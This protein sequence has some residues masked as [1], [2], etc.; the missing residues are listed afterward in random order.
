M[1]CCRII[2]PC[3]C[4]ALGL[5]GRGDRRLRRDARTDRRARPAG[6]GFARSAAFRGCSRRSRSIPGPDLA[7]HHVSDEQMSVWLGKREVRDHASR[8]RPHRGDIVAWVPDANVVFSGDL[9]EYHSACYCG[10][11]HFSDWPATLD[12]LAEFEAAGAGA[13]PRRGAGHAREGRGRHRHDAR[14][15]RDALTAR[16]KDSVAEGLTLKQAFDAAHA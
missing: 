16:A 14:F 6:Q 8:P 15:P 12:R 5:R 9:V 13:R 11:A 4:S 1:C 7:D 2:T 3:A 10:D